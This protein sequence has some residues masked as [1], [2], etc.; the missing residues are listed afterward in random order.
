MMPV[1]PGV[2]PPGVMPAAG[3]MPPEVQEELRHLR[4]DMAKM[5]AAAQEASQNGDQEGSE[6]KQILADEMKEKIE[7]LEEKHKQAAPVALMGL[8]PVTPV[9]MPPGMPLGTSP[10]MVC[11]WACARPAAQQ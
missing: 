9:S 1:P 4:E 2:V 8:P 7:E 10:S 6:F 3:G 5:T 11:Q